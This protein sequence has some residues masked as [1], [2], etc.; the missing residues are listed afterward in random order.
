MT[1][2]K[3]EPGQRV[4]VNPERNANAGIG[5]VVRT[6]GVFVVVDL[7]V[8]L[9]QGNPTHWYAK[10]LISTGDM[11][12]PAVPHIVEFRFKEDWRGI[13][14]S[15]WRRSG[16][17]E[18]KIL[19]RDFAS[20]DKAAQRQMSLESNHGMEYRAVPADKVHQGYTPLESEAIF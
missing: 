11:I 18:T 5:T 6:E 12:A 14:W 2:V 4:K 16:N 20:A 19:F 3:F 10:N 13:R 17:L 1:D 15:E 8:P 9:Q 7:D